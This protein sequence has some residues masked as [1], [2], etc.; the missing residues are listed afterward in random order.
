VDPTRVLPQVPLEVKEDLT[1]KLRPTKILDRG[2]KEL[3]IMQSAQIEE[4]GR[5]NLK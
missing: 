1:L 4:L 2:V 5:G 3:M